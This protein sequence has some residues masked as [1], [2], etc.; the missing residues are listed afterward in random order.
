M[1]KTLICSCEDVTSDDIRHAV[2]KGYSDVE[3]VKRFT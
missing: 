3:S 1:S 2:S